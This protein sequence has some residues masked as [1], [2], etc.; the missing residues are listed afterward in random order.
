MQTSHQ[1]SR[2]SA[3]RKLVDE[4]LDRRDTDLETFVS[5]GR[6]QGKSIE[7]IWLDLRNVTGVPFA[8]RTLYYWIEKLER[9]S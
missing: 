3:T 1:R 9:A 7:E 4:A 2:P 6:T 5:A 8:V